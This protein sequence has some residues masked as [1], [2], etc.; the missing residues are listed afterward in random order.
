M[1]ITQAKGW[2]SP[3]KR[4]DSPPHGPPSA[5]VC[6][7][8]P[9]TSIAHQ[10]GQVRVLSPLR[11]AVALVVLA[12]PALAAARTTVY[13]L[14]ASKLLP[15][16]LEDAPEKLTK[17][18]AE[19]VKGSVAD[20]TVTAAATAIGCTIDDAACLDQIARKNRA[21]EIVFG[22]IRTTDE[23]RVLVKLTRFIVGVERRERTFALTAAAPSALGKQLVRAA[24][25]MFDLEPVAEASSERPRKEPARVNPLLE[26]YDRPRAGL[27]RTEPARTERR[28]GD[29]EKTEVAER[30]VSVAPVAE[31]SDTPARPRGKITTG[32]YAMIGGGAAGAVIG[33]GLLIAAYSLRDD[34]KAAPRDTVE[35]IDRLRELERAGSLRTQLGAVFLGVGSAV[36]ITGVVRAVIQRRPVDDRGVAVVP[37]DGGAAVVFSGS[38]R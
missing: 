31:P 13:Q 14:S 35:Q 2:K 36:A 20:G 38:F 8:G 6:E 27:G 5:S 12:A 11:I 10:D 24:R 1:A 32:T 26:S 25:E 16:S 15:R 37:M 7:V 34:I 19:L 23:K 28:K 9:G 17:A 18:I 30:E 4:G 3:A 21:D 22:T 33:T 29:A